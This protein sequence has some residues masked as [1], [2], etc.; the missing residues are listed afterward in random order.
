VKIGEVMTTPVVT[1][2]PTT[3]YKEIVELLLAWNVSGLPVVDFDDQLVGVVT[4]A[5]LLPKEGY[6]HHRPRALG[7]VADVLWGREHHWASKADGL[8]AGE[9][10][11][12][13][14]V[15][16]SPTD[17]VDNVARRMLN[18]GVKRLPVVD[19][20]KLV[21]IVSRKDIL[22]IFDRPDEE[23]AQEISGMLTDP[24]C[25]PEDNHIRA[26]V[27]DGVVV[28]TGDVRLRSDV[29]V[30]AAVIGRVRG[31][32]DVVDRLQWSEPD[33]KRQLLDDWS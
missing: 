14:V 5:D 29:Q 12:T 6:S 20:G 15:T 9:V 3:Q 21:G 7:V 24:R 2:N 4:E 16:C 8:T 19:D 25:L 30:V 26:Q 10:M 33:P 22:A 17:E 28:L 13:S 32:I 1:V 23:I 27:R 31:V 18:R 11:T